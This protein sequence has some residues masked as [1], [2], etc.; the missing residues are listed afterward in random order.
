MV[1][2]IHIVVDKAEKERY[3]R[4]AAREGK[5][6]SEWLRAAAQEKLAAAQS[7][8]RLETVEELLA[9]F[10]EI[11][12]REK[13]REPDWEEHRKVIEQSIAKGAAPA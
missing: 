11:D 12:G 4:L 7:E 13:G 9:F 6:L 2:R 3:R 10:E 8:S 5:S 1:E